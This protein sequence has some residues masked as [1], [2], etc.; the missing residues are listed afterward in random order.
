MP[1]YG[2]HAP[3]STG[4]R[5]AWPVGVPL[6]SPEGVAPSTCRLEAGCSLL[7]SYGDRNW[8]TE[9]DLHPAAMKP[10]SVFETA[11]ARWSGS[12]SVKVAAA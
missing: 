3:V 9:E 2:R 11:P 10:S 7:L 8:R 4:A 5:R 12:L 6:A 1:L